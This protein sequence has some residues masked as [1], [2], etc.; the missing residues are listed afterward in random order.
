MYIQ[1]NVKTILVQRGTLYL[2]DLSMWSPA[3]RRISSS[4]LLKEKRKEIRAGKKKA[5]DYK[6]DYVKRGRRRDTR[7]FAIHLLS[8]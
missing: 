3:R 4:G 6:R 8:S 7:L 1:R 2:S 5:L